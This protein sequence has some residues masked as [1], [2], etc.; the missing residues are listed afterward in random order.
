MRP[1]VGWQTLVLN[2]LVHP[3]L[4][5]IIVAVYVPKLSYMGILVWELNKMEGGS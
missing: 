3:A 5:I 2:E 1:A 4:L